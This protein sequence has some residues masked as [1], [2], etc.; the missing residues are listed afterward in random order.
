MP[1]WQHD[2]SAELKMSESA[3]GHRAAFWYRLLMD[4]DGH[5]AGRSSALAGKKCCVR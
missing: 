5:V 3:F 1:R 2:D 4:Y